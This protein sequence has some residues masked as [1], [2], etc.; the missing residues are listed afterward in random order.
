MD[1]YR[2]DRHWVSSKIQIPQVIDISKSSDMTIKVKMAFLILSELLWL[3][4]PAGTCTCQGSVSGGRNTVRLQYQV[5]A[6]S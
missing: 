3:L 2:H 5:V 4:T 1:R 6:F